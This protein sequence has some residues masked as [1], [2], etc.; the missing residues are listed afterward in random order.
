MTLKTP[1]IASIV[2][3]VAV[4]AAAIVTSQTNTKN[5]TIIL[6]DKPVGSA[7]LS[8]TPPQSDLKVGET[9]NLDLILSTGGNDATSGVD[10]IIHYDQ[11]VLEV[12]DSDP[13]VEGIQIVDGKLLS[14]VPANSVTLGNGL[15]EFS[16]VMQ[17]TEQ[18]V[19]AN[20]AKLATITFKAKATGTGTISYNYS[21]G[22]LSDTNVIKSGAQPLDLLSRVSGAE[23][24]VK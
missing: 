2:V 5:K 7:H 11:G 20:S 23:I 14:F 1:H 17:P 15:I 3:G 10:A 12:V 8:I 13:S 18:P 6:A 9:V 22:S 24:T 4:I 21:A 19:K 16:A